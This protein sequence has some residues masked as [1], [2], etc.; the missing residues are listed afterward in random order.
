MCLAGCE[1]LGGRESSIR[2]AG[3]WMLLERVLLKTAWLQ[4]CF[5]AHKPGGPLGKTEEEQDAEFCTP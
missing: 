4:E 3:S 2:K 5:D 1:A